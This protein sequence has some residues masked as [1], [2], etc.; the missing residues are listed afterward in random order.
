MKD[1]TQGSVAKHVLGMSVFLAVSMVFQTMYYLVDLYFVSRLGKEAIAGVGLAGNL[2]LVVLALT[3][4]L[5]VGT[6]A[7][8]SHAAGRKDQPRAKLIFNQSFVFSLIVGAG[9]VMGG[10][11]LRPVYCRWLGADPATA[12]AASE[13]LL[14]FIPAL[15]AQFALVSMAAA[16]RGTGIVRPTMIVQVLTVLVNMILAPVLIAGW[17][18]HHPLGVT[19]ASL[20][21]LIAL[22]VAVLLIAAYFL[23][24]ETFVS[25]DRSQ[26]RPDLKI[27]K[28]MLN[29]GLPAGGEFALMGV[30]VVIIYGII[31][32]FGAA[33]QAGFGIGGRV[34]Q[35]LFLPVLAISFA[36]SPV[37]GQNFGARLGNRVR[38]TFFSA[39]AIGTGV[40]FV[41]TL[42][43]H[44]S[45]ESLIR[46]FSTEPEVIAFGADYLRIIS[47]N[48]I[49]MGLI[50]TSSAMFQAMGNSWP[51]LAASSLRLLIFA[52]PASLLSL[53]PGFAIREIWYLSVVTVTVQAVVNLALLG[54]EFRRK[55]IFEAPPVLTPAVGP[56]L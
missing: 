27:W 2:M 24:L 7:L 50:F 37:A 48:F 3:Q 38:Q 11:L 42:L 22:V 30:Y 31:R 44:L 49:A 14:W 15:G 6:T 36:A 40:M 28:S 19:G 55:L 52:L 23:K 43:C 25:F 35:S 12:R 20:A 47:W 1:L 18:T 53:R 51:P 56:E 16:L 32:H 46:I 26:W 21:T 17:G 34:M 39:A 5:G 45:P 8:I 41:L 29:I 13:Y 54:R 9:V 10:F 33:A 4:M